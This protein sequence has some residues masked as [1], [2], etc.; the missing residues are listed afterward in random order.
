MHPPLV[1]HKQMTAL[2]KKGM[3]T[4]STGCLEHGVGVPALP[5]RN[6]GNR[7]IINNINKKG[8]TLILEGRFEIS[9]MK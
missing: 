9:R 5:G 8:L 2:N 3:V 4:Y 7:Q 1:Q 6:T